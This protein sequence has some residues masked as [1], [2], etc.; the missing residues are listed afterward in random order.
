MKS[1]TDGTS[2][3]PESTGSG[4]AE[5]AAPGDLDRLLARWPEVA[6]PA[7]GFDA[8]A[9]R[10]GARLL[11]GG[12]AI[13]DS[14]DA[15]ERPVLDGGPGDEPAPKSN[16]TAPDGP[17]VDTLAALA[18]DSAAPK[19]E[20]KKPSDGEDKSSSSG[21]INF[22]ALIEQG[23][24][25]DAEG[26]RA[27]A[28]AARPAEP[29]DLS[30]TSPSTPVAIAATA[31]SAAR[32]GERKSNTATW[33]LVAVIGIACVVAYTTF[34]ARGSAPGPGGRN[35]A[36]EDERGGSGTEEEAAAPASGARDREAN[37]AEPAGGPAAPAAP[38]AD[39]AD[40]VG[41]A[42][43]PAAE[44]A[45]GS[46]K[47]PVAGRQEARG[48]DAPEAPAPAPPAAAA[49]P[50]ASG[51]EQ[52]PAPAQNTKRSTAD[53][54][55]LISGSLGGSGGP[56]PGQP[57]EATRSNA[58]PEGALP[59]PNRQQIQ[60]GMGRVAGAVR[61]CAGGQSGMAMMRV[62]FVSDGSV[63]SATMA[64]GPFA[65]TPAAACMEN[66]V[67]SARVPAFTNPNVTISYPFVI[68][69]PDPAAAPQ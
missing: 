56:A 43:S 16:G 2:L 5:P 50:Q 48:P 45:S 29:I 35:L 31:P 41:A 54:D 58:P 11:E 37:E 12:A 22:K 67:R 13:D 1:A 68:Q 23:A 62:T 4:S 34:G 9:E 69:P 36:S 60:R 20:A 65:G 39:P 21:V 18:R 44:H 30:R 26:A 14:V 64:G 57:A 7:G 24:A 33:A 47:R 28:E 55:E 8:L 10:I 49:G 15:F 61:A 17:R 46:S 51:A 40:D 38:A 52:A 42:G 3:P 59:Q 66:A 53:L 27:L 63:S 32:P 6:D 25:E 19:R